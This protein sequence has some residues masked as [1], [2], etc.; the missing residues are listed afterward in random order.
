MM[1]K[2][3]K[4][5]LKIA[6]E[7]IPKTRIVYD[8]QR[9][10]EREGVTRRVLTNSARCEEP[11]VTVTVAEALKKTDEQTSAAQGGGVRPTW[12]ETFP[13]K[14]LA[15]EM[16]GFDATALNATAGSTP[17]PTL[18]AAVQAD[19]AE[20]MHLDEE[21]TVEQSVG[22]S[23]TAKAAFP[24]RATRGATTAP[25]SQGDDDAPAD[26]AAVVEEVRAVQKS[27]LHTDAHLLWS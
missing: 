24:C 13:V 12:D 18:A 6:N 15:I 9:R 4:N 21:D 17:R 27:R 20:A 26:A 22:A 2:P 25:S 19:A 10:G 8:A 14:Q 5:A 7:V 1:L 16:D 3:I 23:R 11:Q